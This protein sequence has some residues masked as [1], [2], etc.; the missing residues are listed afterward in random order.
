[1]SGVYCTYLKGVWRLRERD[2]GKG[3]ENEETSP[4]DE[5]RPHLR[6]YNKRTREMT[7][8]KD[9]NMEGD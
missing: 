6:D 3:S 9:G 5:M 2:L 1:M 8:V 7:S 4:E